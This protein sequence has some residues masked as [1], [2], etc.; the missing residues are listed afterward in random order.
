VASGDV[1]DPSV[2]RAFGHPLRLR[3]LTVITEM[4]EAS[5]ALLARELDVPLST[6][7]HHVRILRDLGYLEPTRTEPR[8]GAVERYYRATTAPFV[9]D[10]EW[11]RLPIA[12]RRGIANQLLGQ[13]LVEA[14]EAGHADGFET[15]G[16]HLTRT[17]LELDARGW[18]ELS[19]AV[20]AFLKRVE[21]LQARSDARG[22]SPDRG[23]EPL[24]RSELALLHFP[25]DG[26]T[27]ATEGREPRGA[28][29]G[30]PP[31][32]P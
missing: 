24:R 30:R 26:S 1:R 5:S 31:R 15:A 20:M 17:M 3:L 16:A 27:P 9:G 7:G 23:A 14:Y 10:S 28:R 21:A 11:E 18:R 12:L 32:L 4:G 2:L 19:Q 22:S 6:V 29:R 8:R 25:V 13:V